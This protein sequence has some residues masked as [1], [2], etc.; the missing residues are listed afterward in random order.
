MQVRKFKKVGKNKYKVFFDN[1]DLTLYEDIILKYELLIKK[2]IDTDLIDKI[3]EENRWYEAY[4]MALSYI[5]IKMRNRKEIIKY[6]ENKMYDNNIINSVID[7]LES[8]NLLN[9]KSYI[10]AYIND[11][12]NLSND[13]PYKIKKSLIDLDFNEKD[14]DD[15]L[16]TIDDNI[17]KDKLDKI[18]NKKKSL[19]KNKSYIMFINK[20]KNDLYNL[21]YDKDM[22]DSSLSNIVY[23]SDALKKDFEKYKKRYK[24]E[25]NKI[26]S[27]LFRKGYS[28]EEINNLFD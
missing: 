12:V 20:I 5:D 10:T 23:E 27:A 9:N 24:D 6:L 14:I 4:D 3:I 8:T 2:D 7:K 25:K 26:I 1:T 16:Y 11:K 19:M 17:W 21:G 13:G 22:I 15:Y 18:I 28:Y